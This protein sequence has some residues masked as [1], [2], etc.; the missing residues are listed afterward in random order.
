MAKRMKRYYLLYIFLMLYVCYSCNN[1][2]RIADEIKEMTGREIVFPSG[3]KILSSNDSLCEHLLQYDNIKV[4]T[5]ID[6][7]PCTEC[8]LRA[9]RDWGEC[10]KTINKDVSYILVVQTEDS[11]ELIGMKDSIQLET[12]LLFYSTDTFMVA[13]EL[14]VLTR[15]KTFLLNRENKI[16]LVGE[17]FGN[18]K[19]TQLYK[20]TI[21]SLKKEYSHT[22][23]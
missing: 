6:N 19:L 22:R 9:I 12:P 5:F 21:A 18:E 20:K 13:N 14:N 4:I 3:Y 16:V 10:I 8:G 17:P 1:D 7:L 2:N 23:E 11:K 15:N